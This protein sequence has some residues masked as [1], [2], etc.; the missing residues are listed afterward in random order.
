ML[1]RMGEGTLLVNGC[2]Y[3]AFHPARKY[4]SDVSFGAGRRYKTVR[5]YCSPL[6][7][8]TLLF[9][10]RIPIGTGRYFYATF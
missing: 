4:V 1:S 10:R 9:H 7:A 3:R 5:S 2:L 6:Y 8:H